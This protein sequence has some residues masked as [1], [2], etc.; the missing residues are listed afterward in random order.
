M[1][2]RYARWGTGCPRS[3]SALDLMNHFRRIHDAVKFVLMLSESAVICGQNHRYQLVLSR[4]GAVGLPFQATNVAR[5][6]LLRLAKLQ[7]AKAVEFEPLYFVVL[8]ILLLGLR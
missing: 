1:R 3:A 2:A 7:A 8:A 6:L 4:I 5:R